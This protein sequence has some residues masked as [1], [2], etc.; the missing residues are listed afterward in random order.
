MSKLRDAKR[1][2]ARRFGLELTGSAKRFAAAL[3]KSS[4]IDRLAGEAPAVYL[5]RVARSF[6]GAP[7]GGEMVVEGV[8]VK[9]PAFLKTWAW[10][11]LRYEVMR[12][13][14]AVCMCCGASRKN[15]AQIHVD[16]I[17]PRRKY[18]ELALEISN[19]QILCAD[20][21][22]GK[23]NSDETDWR[24]PPKTDDERLDVEHL[25]HLREHGVLH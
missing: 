2:L 17:K 10:R 22:A 18:P 3:A 25:A 23:N 20:C 9:T 7:R 16:H 4:E 13:Y 5:V 8:N 19:L 14:G 12:R 21:N 24:A 11:K 1:S 6:S 15:G